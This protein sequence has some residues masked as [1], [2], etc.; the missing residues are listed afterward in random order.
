RVARAAR[1]GPAEGGV[2]VGPHPV[3]GVLAPPQ[4][5]RA[6]GRRHGCT[7]YRHAGALAGRRAAFKRARIVERRADRAAVDIEVARRHLADLDLA[8]RPER[9]RG[10]RRHLGARLKD[11]RGQAEPLVA[12]VLDEG[13]LAPAVLRT[14]IE[15][16]A[17]LLAQVAV[18][19]QVG[20]DHPPQ[21]RAFGIDADVDLLGRPELAAVSRPRTFGLLA[22]RAG[23]FR[24][25]GI[26]APL[27]PR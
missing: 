27:Q 10:G 24:Y 6:G 1:L 5:R 22:R 20:D 25:L 15:G 12:A 17:E 9:A 13:D 23:Q 14:E 21:L 11:A 19:P 18:G 16:D 4:A 3:Q 2:E 7:V 8:V 26:V